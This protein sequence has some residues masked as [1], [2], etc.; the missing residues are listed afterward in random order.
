M[1]LSALFSRPCAWLVPTLVAAALLYR[2]SASEAPR[3]LLVVSS[4]S[5]FAT[6]ALIASRVERSPFA[7]DRVADRDVTFELCERYAL[8]LISSTSRISTH[9]NNCTTPSVVWGEQAWRDMGMAGE[10]FMAGAGVANDSRIVFTGEKL[11]EILYFDR[12]PLLQLTGPHVFFLI[13]TR[14]K[15]PG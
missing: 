5:P 14:A 15:S 9:L 1:L 11:E 6:D 12:V 4:L 2:L 7:L 10:G 3:A 13:E 8:V